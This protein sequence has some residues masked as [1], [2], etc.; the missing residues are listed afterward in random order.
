MGR[1]A[2]VIELDGHEK[3]LLEKMIRSRTLGKGVQQRA[4]IVLAAA[5]KLTNIQIVEKYGIEKHRVA[6][7]RS[8]F[9]QLHEQWKQLDEKLRPTMTQ[10]LLLQWFTD[11]KGR[12]RKRR[13]TADQRARIIAL[14]CEPPSKHGYPNT[15]WSVRLLA[16]EAVRQGIVESIAFQT[17]ASF[18][19]CSRPAAAQMR[20]LPEGGGE[21]A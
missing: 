21:G 16:K 8:R 17:V 3:M 9:C 20:V 11:R 14:A 18:L 12:G 4:Q 10:T 5:E 13:I 1:M 2:A 15:H 19:K 7:W 6:R